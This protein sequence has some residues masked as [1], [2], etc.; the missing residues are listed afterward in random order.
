MPIVTRPA[1]FAL[2]FKNKDAVVRVVRDVI[3]ALQVAQ[4]DCPFHSKNQN[5]L[6]YQSA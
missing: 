5:R 3:I 4:R 6:L 1:V 2:E